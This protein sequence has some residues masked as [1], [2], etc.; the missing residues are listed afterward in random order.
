MNGENTQTDAD[1]E[2]EVQVLPEAAI[3]EVVEEAAEVEAVEAVEVEASEEIAVV[4]AVAE[5]TA[6]SLAEELDALVRAFDSEKAEL[7][8]SANVANERIEHLEEQAEEREG[9]IAAMEAEKALAVAG[10]EALKAKLSNPAFDAAVEGEV[11]AAEDGAVEVEGASI[12]DQLMAI[13]DPKDKSKFRREH[14]QEITDAQ[15]ELA[16][17]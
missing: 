3:E 10:V 5:P 17:K 7:L 4:E 8:A 6:P 13:T 2:V 14:A 12:L 1:V 15:R 9:V 16:G 11:E